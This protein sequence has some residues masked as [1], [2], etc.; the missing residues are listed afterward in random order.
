MASVSAVPIV[1]TSVDAPLAAS[2][3]ATPVV[4]IVTPIA[5]APGKARSTVDGTSSSKAQFVKDT[6]RALVLWENPLVS[7]GV[8][9]TILAANYVFAT[10]SP[11]RVLAFALGA[12][13]FAN[14]VFVNAW[15]YGGS[16]FTNSSASGAG[17]KK[18]PTMW[19]LDN[20]N[21]SP[22][23]HQAVHEWTD[24]AVDTI[25]VAAAY[26]ASIV[27]V[28]DNKR[29]IQALAATGFVYLLSG[30]VSSGTLFLVALILAFV[31]PRIYL[32]NKT[33]I[34]GHVHQTVGLVSGHVSKVSGAASQYYNSAAA[35]AKSKVAAA[36][37]KKTS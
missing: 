28:D 37:Q 32:A 34:D 11:I 8:L 18:P 9:A 29:S 12:A 31:T 35:Q 24:F 13:T 2:V 17:V 3:P 21:R 14:L 10:Y 27:A 26:V 22:V 33:L 5:P 1:P 16:M 4:T 30:Y 15:V 25:N 7:G 6:L 23:S 20:A 36:T 19:L